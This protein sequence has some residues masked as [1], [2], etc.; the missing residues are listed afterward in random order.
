MGLLTR[1]PERWRAAPVA[2]VAM[3]SLL[4]LA[5]IGII[6]QNEAAYRDLQAQ[7]TRVQAEILA[8]S[9][10]AAL[11]FGDAEASQEAVNAIRVN[12][13]VRTVGVY[14]AAGQLIA[15]YG[16][17]GADPVRRYSDE[18]PAPGNAVTS[19]V[20][21]TSRGERI[22][23]VF[24]AADPEPVS[25]RL[26]RYIVI[27]LLMLMAVLVVVVLG[28]AQGALRRVNRQLEERAGALAI[29]NAE[30]KIQI[31]ERTKA[32]DQ[33]RQAHKMQALGQLTGGIAH[34][35]NNLLTV[36]QGSA[37]MLRRPGLSEEK[38]LRFAEAVVQAAARAAAL[39]GQLLAFARRQPLQPEVIEVNALIRGMT[40][41][42]DRTLG[43]RIEVRTA[44][45]DVACTVEADRTQLES[46]L[47]NVA[48]NARDAMPEGGLLTI[49]TG[50]LHEEGSGPMI[51]L[52]VSDSGFG[53]DE[54]TVERAFEPFFTTKM[55]GKGTGLGLSQVYGFASQSGGE[56]RIES[57]P[58]EGTTVTLLLPC[59]GAPAGAGAEDERF[60]GERGRTARILLVEDNEEVGE[61]ARDL[62]AE[63]GHDVRWARSGEEALEAAQTGD[64]DL[65][66]SDVV[67]PGMNGLDL[68]E[69][70]GQAR[71][72]LPVI[73]TTG[74]SD[75]IARSG[76]GG[77]A[78]ILKPYRLDTLAAAI[79]QALKAEG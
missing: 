45:A 50:S 15:G 27:G 71:P 47:L 9:V 2:I 72:D 31:G 6:L 49:R 29:A 22:G 18:L 41:L 12:R 73:L 10:T 63:L 59:S 75:E 13:Q 1:L 57:R 69:R 3:V 66:F 36:I 61:F 70:L 11:D 19:A 79:D 7:E 23:T 5:G 43:E 33:L 74:Y 52:S 14:N 56:V 4:L 40:D 42:L 38:R 34:D 46:A 32:E 64:F 16:R 39:T 65:V 35:F 28:V 60:L 37:D 62:L 54:D 21:V 26:T 17:D 51:A 53:M 67:M 20:P 68:A 77:R 58:G 24:L 55:T 8:A 76:A 48:V 78:V 44:L 25:R 30:L